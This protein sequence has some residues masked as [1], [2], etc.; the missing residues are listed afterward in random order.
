MT[1]LRVLT[2]ILLAIFAV[3]LVFAALSIKP[4]DSHGAATMSTLLTGIV[5]QL[6]AV[7]MVW[8]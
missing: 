5:I 6:L 4:D 1:G 2:T 7:V 8:R 3:I